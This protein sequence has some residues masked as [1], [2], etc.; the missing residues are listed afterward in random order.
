MCNQNLSCLLTSPKNGCD[1]TMD[2]HVLLL[3]LLTRSWSSHSKE[4]F[5]LL[6][7]AV[8]V[9]STLTRHLQNGHALATVVPLPR[10]LSWKAVRRSADCVS[11][12]LCRLFWLEPAFQ[13]AVTQSL[14]RSFMHLS[15]SLTLLV[16]FL[17]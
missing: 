16:G 3:R 15:L 6:G 7:A 8:C 10:Y 11:L 9:L 17:Y 4:V 2:T 12:G 14:V 13:L 1:T 5:P